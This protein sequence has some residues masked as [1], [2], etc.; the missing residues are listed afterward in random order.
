MNFHTMK[1]HILI[2][3]LP[4]FAA[5]RFEQKLTEIMKQKS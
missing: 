5:V 4:I 3:W 2:S 1:F